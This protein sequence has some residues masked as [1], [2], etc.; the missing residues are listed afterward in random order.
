[1]AITIHNQTCAHMAEDGQFPNRGPSPGRLWQ[2]STFRYSFADNDSPYFEWFDDND[3]L[4][5]GFCLG[6]FVSPG[7]DLG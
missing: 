5:S 7:L 6:G 4:C 1:M 2:E 3:D